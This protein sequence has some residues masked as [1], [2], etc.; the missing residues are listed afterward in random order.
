MKLSKTNFL[1]YRDC[2][3]NAWLKMHRPDFY[4]AE[5]LSV[6]DQTIIATGNEVDVLA[7]EL[8]PAGVE[9]ARRNSDSTRAHILARTPVLYQP[10]FETER[11]TTACD[12]IVWNDASDTYDLYEVKAS[13]SG[14][15][16]K[17]KNELYACDIA[18]QAEVLR[19]NNVPLGRL[20][21]TRLNSD[22]ERGTS[23]DVE[24]LFTREDFTERVTEMLDAI[25]L[26]MEAAYDVLQSKMPLPT[27]CGCILKGRSAH[28]TTFAFTNPMVPAYGVHDIA[29]IGASKRKLADLIDRNILKI[30]DVPDDFA[31][32]ELQTNQVRAAKT[33][34]ATI[35]RIAIAEFL[36]A[37]RHPVSFLDY[38]TFPAAIPRFPGYCP[39][40]QIPF[41]FSLDVI[42]DPSSQLIHREFLHTTPDNPDEAL[43]KA[44]KS[45][46]PAKGSIVVWNQTFERGIN[47]K[48]GK[49]NPDFR[50]W[51]AD[52]DTRIVDL[53]EVFSMQAYVH[54][55]FRGRTSIKRILPVLVPAFSYKS[56]AIQEGATATARWNEV[57][58]GQADADTA[59]QVRSNL[60]AYCGLDTRAMV[61]IWKEL[62]RAVEPRRIL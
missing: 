27:P 56:L 35:D 47:D 28:C 24:A 45:A 15:D 42:E 58:T 22:Y 33:N 29:R 43:L 44:L 62:C 46:L 51:L 21:L 4:E 2:A 37:I 52:I 30:E 5:P 54:P 48:L 60:L 14:D 31:L 57:V 7:R 25:G 6:F 11:F 12:I 17:A 13:T 10:V 8:F 3:H 1:I 32:S 55:E 40:D 23:L 38:E 18:F 41:Q 26:E 49:R 34:R 53:M 16:K 39:F 36:E 19:Q 59:E 9:V 50:D 20:Y 61:E